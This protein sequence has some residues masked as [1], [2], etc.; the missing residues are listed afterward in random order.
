MGKLYRFYCLLKKMEEYRIIAENVSAQTY[1]PYGVAIA[2]GA[3]VYYGLRKSWKGMERVI[4]EDEDAQREERTRK[5]S[6]DD[7]VE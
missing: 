2:L 3:L 5:D 4:M 7:G 6:L 1:A